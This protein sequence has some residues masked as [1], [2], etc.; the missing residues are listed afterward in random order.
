VSYFDE[1][2]DGGWPRALLLPRW[3]LALAGTGG[4]RALLRVGASVAPSPS[5]LTTRLVAEY[6]RRV[7]ELPY[8]ASHARVRADLRNT[9]ADMYAEEGRTPREW[10]RLRGDASAQKKTAL[11][12]VVL[13]LPAWLASPACP[14]L[15]YARHRR[16]LVRMGKFIRWVD[17]AAD[18]AADSAAGSANLVRR[19]L[20][21]SGAN[22]GREAVLAARVAKRGR[23]VVDEG[24][25]LTG[26]GNA[27]V[28]ASAGAVSA[29]L[30]TVLVAWVGAPEPRQRPPI[31]AGD[32]DY[33]LPPSNS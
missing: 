16:W 27:A 24:W 26:R 32:S 23:W 2:V 6:F 20:A 17:D 1:M 21:R 19:A 7:A 8:V 12:F 3:A 25:A 13:G 31:R 28:S 9:I 30:A 5:R 22:G 14:P 4:G 15:Q 11:P 18:L 33:F 29:V 10:R